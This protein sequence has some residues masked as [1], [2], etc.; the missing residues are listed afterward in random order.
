MSFS[1]AYKISLICLLAL[2]MEAI[3]SYFIFSSF[4]F[5]MA[6]EGSNYASP[7]A[8]SGPAGTTARFFYLVMGATVGGAVLAPLIALGTWAL[9]QV[10]KPKGRNP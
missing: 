6:G 3:L 7:R 1:T 8:Y 10:R 5:Y 2:A 9:G 4:A